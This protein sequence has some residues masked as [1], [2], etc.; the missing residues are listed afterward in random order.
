VALI[1]LVNIC[2]FI[3]AARIIW[4]QIR[5]RETSKSVK[6]VL[7][8]FNSAVLLVVVLGLTWIIGVVVVEVEALA[9][10]AY[11]YTI[12]VAF[13]GLLLFLVLVVCSKSVR[14]GVATLKKSERN[15][16]SKGK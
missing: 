15:H 3:M 13:Q 2:F 10:L 5:K 11:I 6:K 14:K 12:V 1:F 7:G 8:W 4:I 9:P 16:V